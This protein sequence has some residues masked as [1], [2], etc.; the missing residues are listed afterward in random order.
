METTIVALSSGSLPAGVAVIRLSGPQSQ[1][2]CR[3]L[4]GLVPSPRK[5]QL[6]SLEHPQSGLLLDEALVLSFPAPN[7]F[8]GEDVVELHCHGGRA[9]VAAVLETILQFDDVRLAEPGEFSRRAFENGRMDLTELEGLSD[10]IAAETENQRRAALRQ[11]GGHFRERLDD[12]RDRIIRVRAFLEAQFDFTDEEDVQR[13]E[14]RAFW[15]D[16]RTLRSEIEVELSDGNA[17]EIA[18]DGLRVA[19]LGPPNSGK[20]SLL[21]AL[22]QR[23]VAIVTDIAGTTRDVLE[24][25]LNIDGQLVLVQDT[26]GIRDTPDAIEAEGIRRAYCAAEAADVVFWLKDSDGQPVHLPSERVRVVQTKADLRGLPVGINPLTISTTVQH[27]LSPILNELS[28]LCRAL[29][30]GMESTLI[31]R[32]RHRT[33]LTLCT[34]ELDAALNGSL[35]A[36]LRTDH[37]RRAGDVVGRLTGRIDTEDL[38]DVIFSEFCVGK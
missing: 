27:G 2:I 6:R 7:S 11:A 23:D 33:E 3:S 21:N 14:N 30:D 5:A 10:L 25:S 34:K 19:L 15:T 22:A 31:T 4:C 38:L 18:R 28:V 8:T 37:L 1:P 29:G 12:W 32:E 20:S 26:A 13:D 24:V 16:V 35:D 17:G 9:T 36:E